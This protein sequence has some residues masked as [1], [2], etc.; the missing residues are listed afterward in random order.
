MR[1]TRIAAAAGALAALTALTA[2]APPPS[3]VAHPLVGKWNVEY[4]RGRQNM[5]GEVTVLTVTATLESSEKGDSLVGTLTPEATSDGRPI[6]PVSKLAGTGS[7]NSA[8]MK[9]TSTSR[10]NMN[11]DERTVNVSTT[12]ELKA[13]G[14]ILTGTMARVIADMPAAAYPAPVKGTRVK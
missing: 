5:N 9:S 2:A 10:I 8:T 13:D 6:P 1:I 4:E 7:G 11:G 14:D 12:W 3:T